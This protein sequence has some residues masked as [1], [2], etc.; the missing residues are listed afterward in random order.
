ML[1]AWYRVRGT[2]IEILNTNPDLLILNDRMSTTHPC[3]RTDRVELTWIF[4]APT[5]QF[6]SSCSRIMSIFVR[7]GVGKD[8]ILG[9]RKEM[10]AILLPD[11]CE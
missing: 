8:N 7:P 2:D 5:F 11:A 3:I 1:G 4:G 9:A 10:A 6:L